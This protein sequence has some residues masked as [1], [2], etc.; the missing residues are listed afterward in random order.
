[1]NYIEDLNERFAE[2]SIDEN[3]SKISFIASM[4]FDIYTYDDYVDALFANKM[5]DV[6]KAIISKRTFDYHR[7]GENEEN[8]LNYLTMVNF[9]F[10]K[11]KLEWGTSIRGAWLMDYEDGE[12]IIFPDWVVSKR[13]ISKFLTDLIT[14]KDL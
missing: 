2:Y 4:V 12:Y 10:L 9:P 8:Y 6:I 11:G 5:I 3:R 1:M 13:D 14:W 7:H